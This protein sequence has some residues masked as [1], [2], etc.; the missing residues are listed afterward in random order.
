M[1]MRSGHHDSSEVARPFA[2]QSED[3]T[4]EAVSGLR[5]PFVICP[6][7]A[8]KIPQAAHRTLVAYDDIRKIDWLALVALTVHYRSGKQVDAWPLTSVHG[9]DILKPIHHAQLRYAAVQQAF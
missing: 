2:A 8:T 1:L 9:I 6:S 5:G 7:R 4:R 3:V